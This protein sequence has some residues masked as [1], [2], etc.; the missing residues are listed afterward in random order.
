MP[1][2][3]CVWPLLPSGM[4]QTTAA[5]GREVDG[6]LRCPAWIRSGI[7][8]ADE[9]QLVTGERTAVGLAS[10][11][12]SRSVGP[13]PLASETMPGHAPCGRG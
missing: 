3:R 1:L 4:L 12:A 8:P 5:A 13:L 2:A 10:V 11:S 7:G 9:R 6:G